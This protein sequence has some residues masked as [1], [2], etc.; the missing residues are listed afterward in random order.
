M[1]NGP[2]DSAELRRVHRLHRCLARGP[3]LLFAAFVLLCLRLNDG[4][5]RLY[6]VLGT[7][8]VS[9]FMRSSEASLLPASAIDSH[10]SRKDKQTHLSRLM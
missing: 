6:G 4:R 3:L 8:R 5:K 1:N 9:I 7:N 2:I 10:G